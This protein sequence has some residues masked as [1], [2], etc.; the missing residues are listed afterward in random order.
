MKKP[1]LNRTGKIGAMIAADLAVALLG[2]FVL[3]SP[4]R[5]QATTT[6]NSVNAT[7]AEI[8]AAQSD[9]TALNRAAATPKETQP[10]IETADLYRLAKAMP[11]SVDMPDLLLELDQ[12][13]RASGVSVLTFS[14]G[15]AT[16]VGTYSVIPVNVTLTGDFYSLTD[17]LYRLRRLVAVRDGAL[18]ATGRLFSVASVQLTPSSTGSKALSATVTVDAYSYGTAAANGGVPIPPPTTITTSTD[19]TD[20]TSTDSAGA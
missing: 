9:A 10:A 2:W 11:A 19:T 8:Q 14:P 12:V 20:T 3:V 15:A 6:A 13:S 1:Q 17:M 16:A 4:Q 5:H 7:Q 18:D